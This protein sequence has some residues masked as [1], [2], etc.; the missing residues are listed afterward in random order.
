MLAP[1]SGKARGAAYI[2]AEMGIITHAR[3]NDEDYIPALVPFE[4]WSYICDEVPEVLLHM[5]VLA[6]PYPKLGS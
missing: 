5:R 2:Q 3:L 1:W 4:P 6:A